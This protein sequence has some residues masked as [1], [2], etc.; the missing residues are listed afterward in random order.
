M[1]AGEWTNYTNA[2][3]IASCTKS[4]TALSMA[5]LFDM[6]GYGKQA[7]FVVPSLD[8]VVV[9]LG[10]DRKLNEHPE[11]YHELWKRLMDAVIDP[12]AA[13]PPANQS[14]LLPFDGKSAGPSWQATERDDQWHSHTIDS[15]TIQRGDSISVTVQD[16]VAGDARLDYIELRQE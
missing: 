6:S 16:A 13:A 7:C 10:A 1:V 4:L 3:G 12:P 15:V 2:R 14:R 5:K 8:L 9:R 11:Y